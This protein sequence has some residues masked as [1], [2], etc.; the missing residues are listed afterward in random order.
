MLAND[1]PQTKLGPDN[2]KP[3][4]LLEVAKYERGHRETLQNHSPIIQQE[5][6]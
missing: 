1:R 3:N 5:K 2:F 6:Q 4:L